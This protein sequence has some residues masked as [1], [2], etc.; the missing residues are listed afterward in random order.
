[1]ATVRI[2]KVDRRLLERINNVDVIGLAPL[3]K[4]KSEARPVATWC[5]P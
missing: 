4:R 2:H 1:M 5:A 3:K